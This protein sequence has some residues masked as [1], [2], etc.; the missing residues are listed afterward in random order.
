MKIEEIT[1]A[2]AN[3]GK[4]DQGHLA[5]AAASVPLLHGRYY[6][7]LI[8]E[9]LLLI[10]LKSHQE[11]IAMILDGFFAKTLT[12]SEL[13]EYDL[14]YSDKKVLRADIQKNIAV[15]PKMIDITLKIAVQSEKV[16]YLEDIIKQ[17]H[18]MNYTIKNIIDVRKFEAGQ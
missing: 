4:I 16:K 3:D 6:K 1:T 9:R 5:S 14:E 11:N 17:I 7:M 13:K 2:W 12:I 8:E 18:S 15:H 10:K